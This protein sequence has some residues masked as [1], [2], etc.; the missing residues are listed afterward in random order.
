MQT[1]E[2]PVLRDIVLIGGGHSHVGVLK[3]FAMN[4]VPGVRLTLICR[5]T[6]TPYSG[7]LPGYVAGHYS[8]DDVH[9][10]LSRLAEFAGARFYRDEAIGLD[11]GNKR[12]R[13][14]SR[15]DV[16][17]D[18]LSVNIGS[19]PRVEEVRGAADHAVPV[20]PITGFNARWLTLLSRID[21]HRGP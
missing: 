6:H 20:K 2:Q 21:N 8:Y 5:D 18:L 12:V 16:P 15:P 13:C 9:I 7:M 19:S 3:R 1:P 4:P 17:Y 10:D 11:R 14:R